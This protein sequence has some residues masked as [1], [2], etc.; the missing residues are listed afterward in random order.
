MLEKK[1]FRKQQLAQLAQ[2]KE[3]TKKA[4][5]LLATKLFQTSAWKEA[6]SLGVTLA[7]EIEV[8]TR[9]IIER[10]YAEGKQ[11]A[12]PRTM[13]KRQMVFLEATDATDLEVS[14]FGVLEPKYASE[15]I[16]SEPELMLVPGIAFALDSH[17]RVGFGGGYYD[18]Y[19][20]DFPGNTVAL[21]APA[22]AY[23]TATWEVEAFD[24]P[25][26][27]LITI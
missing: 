19:L 18:R 1:V 26:D 14:S 17:Y 21:V 10:A 2:E 7:S 27:Q 13:P 16:V 3:A 22:M 5:K 25:L 8:P 4:A 9:A 6:K 23:P 24:I 15:R 12:F 11:V 20:K